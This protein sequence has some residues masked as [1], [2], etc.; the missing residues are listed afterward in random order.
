MG[1]EIAHPPTVRGATSSEQQD[2][3]RLHR[4]ADV[5]TEAELRRALGEALGMIVGLI[6]DRLSRRGFDATYDVPT[7]GG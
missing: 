1:R 3:N 4:T 6:E 7:D 2:V 5:G